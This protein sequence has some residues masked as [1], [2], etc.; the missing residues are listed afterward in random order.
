MQEVF[1]RSHKWLQWHV[2]IVEMYCLWPIARRSPS[3]RGLEEPLSV[4]Y[5]LVHSKDCES[6]GV[7]LAHIKLRKS[8]RK[9]GEKN[10]TGRQNKDTGFGSQKRFSAQFI[11]V[12]ILVQ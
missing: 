4:C 11:S 7:R 6:L 5:N 12:K 3:R 10:S 9:V 2:S 8:E 1:S